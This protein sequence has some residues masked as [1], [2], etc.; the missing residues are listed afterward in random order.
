MDGEI[1]EKLLALCVCSQVTNGRHETNADL[2]GWEL[3]GRVADRV[4]E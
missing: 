1:D 4:G 2:Q 3:E